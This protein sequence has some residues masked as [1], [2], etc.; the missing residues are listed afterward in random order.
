MGPESRHAKP[1]H[2]PERLVP[3][4]M[5]TRRVLSPGGLFPNLFQQGT[6]LHP[7]SPERYPVMTEF[8]PVLPERREP[9]TELRDDFPELYEE[10][11]EVREVGKELLTEA[12]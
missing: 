1:Q 3:F 8:H 4:D 6:D 7:A 11:T 5:P 12:R 2:V 9:V 10:L